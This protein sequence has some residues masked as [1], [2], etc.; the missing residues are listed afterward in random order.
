LVRPLVTE[1]Q[2]LFVEQQIERRLD[3]ADLEVAG[4]LGSELP[5]PAP[6]E[7]AVKPRAGGAIAAIPIAAVI[8]VTMFT[9]FFTFATEVEGT[10]QLSGPRTGDHVFTPTSCRSGQ[11]SGFFGVELRAKDTPDVTIRLVRDPVQGDMIA[12]ERGGQAPFVVKPSGCEAMK[13]DVVRT[14]TTINDVRNLEGSA[15]VLCPE[16]RGDLKFAGCH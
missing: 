14:S 16:L 7:A 9:L 4:E 5:L 1:D 13:L 15:I 6:V 8:G 10:L 12:I 3:L 2:A 11:L